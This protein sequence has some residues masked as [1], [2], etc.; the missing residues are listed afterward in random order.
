MARAVRDMW[1]APATNRESSGEVGGAVKASL[2]L[3]DHAQV[4]DGKFFI[5]GGGWS[6]TGP[7]P[8]PF[9]LI[10]DIKVPWHS[11]GRSHKLR[12]E[13]L[14]GDGQPVMVETPES[15][16]QPL[17][18]EGEF[19]VAPIPG[20]KAG[21]ELTFPFAANIGPQPAITPGG[22][23]EWRLHIDGKTRDEWRVTFA[24]RPELAQ[25]G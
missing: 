3:A 23:Y 10:A 7:Q 4:V 5:S 25:T 19:H 8:M 17:F 9:A 21:S 20:I 11:I 6:I 15:G 24:T 14:D 2:M 16:E 13:L 12:L 1:T 18:V 22:V